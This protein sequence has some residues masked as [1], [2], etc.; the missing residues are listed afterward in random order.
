MVEHVPTIGRGARFAE[1]FEEILETIAPKRSYECQPHTR[2]G[3][4]LLFTP[5]FSPVL[6]DDNCEKRFN[7]FK[8]LDL[9]L[10]KPLKLLLIQMCTSPG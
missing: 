2:E 5:G 6:A 3:D 7:G 10:G 1:V 8:T 9:V 4:W